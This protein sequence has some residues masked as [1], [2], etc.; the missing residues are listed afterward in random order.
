MKNY[1][2]IIMALV[3][4]GC[5]E[6]GGEENT[7]AVAV[8]QDEVSEVMETSENEMAGEE[9]ADNETS[10]MPVEEEGVETDVVMEEMEDDKTVEVAETEM[11]KTEV[12]SKVEEAPSPVEGIA[13]AAEV[14]EAV[15]KPDHSVWDALLRKNVSS[16]GKVNYSGMKSSLTKINTYVDHLEGFTDLSALSRNEKLAYWINLYNAV[17]VQLI[18]SNYPVSSITKLHGGK[19]WD[20]KLITIGSK[21]YSLN[22]IENDIIRPR[23]KEARIHFA[24]NCAAKSCPKLLN[25]AF[26]GDQLSSQLRR[27]TKSFVNGSGNDIAAD[28][29]AISKIFEWYKTD[30]KNGDLIAFLNDYSGTKINTDATIE[31]KEYD[32]ALNE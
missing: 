3:L 13:P 6:S 32:W 18:A 21:Q 20:K 1:V 11:G 23:F 31:F 4:I 27:Q 9:M 15:S 26:T 24:V 12:V 28:K 7:L 2:V 5:G 19:P 29:I 14:V 10:D 16:S 22:N 30:F 25:E 8:P 17:T